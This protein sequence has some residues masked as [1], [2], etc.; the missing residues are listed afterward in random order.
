MNSTP[1]KLQAIYLLL[2]LLLNLLLPILP[3]FA[4]DQKAKPNKKSALKEATFAK[5]S[6]E[7]KA[8]IDKLPK[9]PNVSRLIKFPSIT[10][11]ESKKQ[12]AERKV[13]ANVFRARSI[14]K[15]S[16][17]KLLSVGTSGPP[18]IA[19]L[20]RALK[21]DP[22]LIYQY[23]ANNVD[24]TPIY[25]VMKGSFGALV[26]GEA[27]DFDQA[28]LMVALLREAGFTANFVLGTIKLNATQ[29]SNWLGVNTRDASTVDEL[30]ANGAI[31]HEVKK[32]PD[33]SL[34]FVRLTHMWVQANIGGT[35]YVFDPSFKSYMYQDG[36][37]DLCCKIGYYG[38]GFISKAQEGATITPISVQ[39]MNKDNIRNQLTTM[40]G[41]LINWIRTYNPAATV[42]DIIGGRT[43]DQY[44]GQLRQTSLPYQNPGDIPEIFTDIPDNYRTIYQVAFLTNQILSRL[45]SILLE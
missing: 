4:A 38:P 20:A 19:E 5:L 7:E 27:N 11:E 45:E 36:V 25:G 32:K 35:D 12:I 16:A 21:N 9:H 22:D 14:Q 3:T 24:Y 30:L 37:R 8:Y 6:P 29:T 42:A 41:N 44:L 18:S 23:V 2:S 17:L 10:P 43:I 1:K 31:P 26:D 33:G 28:A 34:N 13:P 39:N 15:K 40:A